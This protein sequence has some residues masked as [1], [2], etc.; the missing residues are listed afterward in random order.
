MN[1]LRV[2]DAT[3]FLRPERAAFLALLGSL[4]VDEWNAPTEC[5]EWD[6]KG[7]ALHVLGDDLSLLS[8]GRDAATSGLSLLA[9]DSPGL[10]FRQLLDR[11]NEQWVAAAS[12]LSTQLVAA[13]LTNTGEWTDAY[14]RSVDLQAG[15]ES[16][17]FFGSR[18]ESSP[19][20]HA[21]AREYAERWIHH[22]QIRRA[23]GRPPTGDDLSAPALDAVVLGFGA[24]NPQLGRFTI[25]NRSWSFGLG[26]AVSLDSDLATLVLSRGL[27][28]DDTR[29]ALTGEPSMVDLVAGQTCL[30]M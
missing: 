14:Y 29:R 21:V 13:L 23:L 16:V 28:L 20:W 3:P 7:I 30:D 8:R 17:G 26:A 10:S 18:G 1:P 25:G 5:P 24:R 11:F 6:V 9:A 2:F 4:G 22:N 15:G 12:Y 27:S 19:H